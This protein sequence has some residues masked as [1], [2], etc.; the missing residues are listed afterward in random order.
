[1][2]YFMS[3]A[4]YTTAI[5]YVRFTR[6]MDSA[7]SP[8]GLGKSGQNAKITWR[9]WRFARS[10]NLFRGCLISQTA[11]DAAKRNSFR[12]AKNQKIA[13]DF[14]IFCRSIKFYL[15]PQAAI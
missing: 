14:L 8:P 1:M 6:E 13:S 7:A 9:F 10:K 4:G 12:A 2:N 5:S 3:C 11:A 15:P